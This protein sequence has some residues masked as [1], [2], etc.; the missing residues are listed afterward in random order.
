M[1]AHVYDI[2]Q[3]ADGTR[4]LDICKPEM[5]DE[6]CHFTVVSKKSDRKDV[7]D[8]E[9][10]RQQDIQI[11]GIVHAYGDQGE[12]ILSHAR[13][14]HGGAEKFV[15]N[16]ALLHGF[17]AENSRTAFNDPAL[18]GGHHHSVFKTAQ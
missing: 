9:Q 1:S 5:T 18:K 6:Q 13:Q 14:F 10:Y 4:F 12:I 17:S 15:P 8:L 7:G 11:R 3:L 2:V 16:P